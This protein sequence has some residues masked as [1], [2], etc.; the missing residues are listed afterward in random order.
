MIGIDTNVLIRFF[1]RDS[2]DQ[3][4]AARRLLNSL[5]PQQPCWIGIANLL[6]IEWVLRSVYSH[7]RT[8]IAG[9]FDNL[10]AMDNV[11]IERHEAVALALTRFRGGKAGFADCLIAA[12]AQT[13]GCARVM[14]F[15]EIAA[16]DAGMELL[17]A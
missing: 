6:E 12:S 13:A 1:V 7:S 5:T 17:K 15:D 16:R 14:T 11:V 10:L 8:G 9:I 4:I 3:L 2:P